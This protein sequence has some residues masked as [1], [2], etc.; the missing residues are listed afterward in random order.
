MKNQPT[1][2]LQ[3]IINKT[4]FKGLI[5]LA[6]DCAQWQLQQAAGFNAIFLFVKNDSTVGCVAEVPDQA[7]DSF[8]SFVRIIRDLAIA[9]NVTEGVLMNL[10]QEVSP[11]A[12]DAPEKQIILLVWQSR[13]DTMT[14][15]V[16]VHRNADGSFSH[17]GLG[18]SAHPFPCFAHIV[19][20]REPTAAARTTA[21]ILLRKHKLN[22]V[23]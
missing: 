22:I 20:K 14:F 13:T 16:P 5:K 10:M 6:A 21:D 18:E 19:P 7:G 1:N 23:L 4:A 9:Q 15:F 8:R 17:L 12:P 2:N 11:S 3:A